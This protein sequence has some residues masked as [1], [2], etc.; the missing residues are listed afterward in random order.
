[1]PSSSSYVPE[2]VEGSGSVVD[3]PPRPPEASDGRSRPVLRALSRAG[4]VMTAV[5]VLGAAAGCQVGGSPAQKAVTAQKAA[6]TTTV[7]TKIATT[8]KTVN[9]LASAPMFVNPSSPAMQAMSSMKT[10]QPSSAATLSKIANTPSALWV[11]GTWST[12]R[13]RIMINI[14]LRNARAH[15]RVALIVIFNIPGTRGGR[16]SGTGASSAAAY[17]SW[18]SQAAAG[19]QGLGSNAAVVIEPGALASMN[20]LSRSQQ[21]TRY[22]LL[23][24]AESQWI[25]RGAT[26]Y[27]DAGDPSWQSPSTMAQR[28]KTAWVPGLRGFSVNVAAF[29]STANSM[30]WGAKIVAAL[31]LNLHFVIDTSR[32]GM[33]TPTSYSWSCNR[34]G[35]AIGSSPTT[36]TGSTMVDA[37]L[38]IK[39]PGTSDGTCNGGPKA[40]TFWTRAAINLVINIRIVAPSSTRPTTM[41]TMTTMTPTA[42]A[43]VMPTPTMTTTT[44]TTVV[45]PPTTAAVV[46][47]MT[48]TAAPTVPGVSKW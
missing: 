23:K 8:V 7:T 30:T 41:P 3:H 39:N 45:P 46:P 48:P 42:T 31:R 14:Y 18:V 21:Q 24:Y 36:R 40:G 35:Q 4:A 25:S 17:R 13:V 44:T 15:H 22:S 1:V 19:A 26:V 37:L 29:V 2:S 5:A 12:A 33:A 28:I 9:T 47:G 27:L 20:S 32:N 10:T 16:Y 6:S 43:T 38:W 11:D 34:S